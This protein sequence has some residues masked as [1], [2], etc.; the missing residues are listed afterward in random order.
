MVE[1]RA[2]LPVITC[3]ITRHFCDSW[4]TC[5]VNSAGL[6]TCGHNAC[7]KYL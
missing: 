4:A 7:I 1:L 5:Y 2:V 3:S 6:Y